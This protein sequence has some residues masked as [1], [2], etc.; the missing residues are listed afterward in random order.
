MANPLLRSF[1]AKQVD[2]AAAQRFLRANIYLLYVSHALSKSDMQG[3]EVVLD[4]NTRVSMLDAP[5]A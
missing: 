5:R 3:V 2:A 4:K 1:L